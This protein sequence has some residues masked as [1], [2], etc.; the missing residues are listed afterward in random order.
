MLRQLF[1]RHQDKRQLY[2][3]GIGTFLGLIFL[4]TSTH[5]LVKVFQFGKGSDMLGPNV[6]LVQKRVTSSN[7]LNL[8][9]TDFTRHEIQKLR[10]KSFVASVEPVLCNNFDIS[11][12]TADPLVPRFR[13]DVFI[14]SISPSFLD[15]QTVRWHW[16]PTAKYV[17]IILPRD[18]LTMLNTF[19]SASG[20]PQV[21][22]ELAKDIR[23]RFT[24]KSHTNK[25]WIDARIIGFTNEVS[26]ILVPESFM[27]YGKLHYGEASQ[28]KI[29][30]V[31]L[32]SKDGEFG[33]VEQ[34]MRERGLE[35]KNAQ[36]LIGRLK[37][38]VG[39]LFFV[40]LCIAA[41]AV[42]LAG[43]VLIQYMQLLF[44]KNR[45]EI[46]T[47][48]RLGYTHE[49]IS[50]TFSRYFVYV[51]GL[52]CC[53]GLGCFIAVKILLDH[54]FHSGGLYL[55]TGLSWESIAICFTAYGLFILSS[56]RTAQ[57]EVT[58]AV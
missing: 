13:S 35:S 32:Q 28:D 11:F 16:Y 31:M 24:L 49:S 30:Q 58:Q 8:A 45:Y 46:S 56:H 47:L 55:D 18:F 53:V 37:S 41:V 9:K 10:S 3:A 1:F 33:K 14:Q 34:F 23:F 19:M 38:V 7:T 17:P 12:E 26:S 22:E 51:F 21:S 20:I 57:R 40:I 50:K 27:N 2:I 44:S 15:V 5:Y 54:V 43:L 52:I 48:I 36:V 42:F 6:I 39:T 25:E 4:V 29:T